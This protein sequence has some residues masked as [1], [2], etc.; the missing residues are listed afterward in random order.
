MRVRA[1]NWGRA[2]RGRDKGIEKGSPRE[3]SQRGALGRVGRRN[4][5][6]GFWGWGFRGRSSTGLDGVISGG[7]LMGVRDNGVYDREAQKAHNERHMLRVARQ[8]LSMS[9]ANG[10]LETGTLWYPRCSCIARKR[11]CRTRR[12]Q[13]TGRVAAA[14]AAGALSDCCCQASAG[15]LSDCGCGSA[16]RLRE[17]RPPAC[18]PQRAGTWHCSTRR[19]R[20]GW[21]MGARGA[22]SGCCH[23]RS[24][25]AR[26]TA[27]AC[28]P[29]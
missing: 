25:C 15:A 11:C 17:P 21:E 23:L 1:L 22:R 24:T 12:A 18:Q 13:L 20:G 29:G 7:A 5:S 9:H 28:W 19:K 10:H 6:G 14:V 4:A 2:R 3:G 26:R 16:V 8:R 27:C